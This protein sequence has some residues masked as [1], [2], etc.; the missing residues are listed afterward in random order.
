MRCLEAEGNRLLIYRRKSIA[1]SNPAAY[2]RVEQVRALHIPNTP[3]SYGDGRGVM[4]LG[5]DQWRYS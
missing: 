1:G 3:I 5:G 2:D 4:M